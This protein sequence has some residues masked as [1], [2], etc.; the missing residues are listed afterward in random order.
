MN[1]DQEKAKREIDRLLDENFPH[2]VVGVRSESGIAVV[3]GKGSLGDRLE[4]L[5]ALERFFK[6]FH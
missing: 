2:F 5:W 4:L 6:G 1:E 3:H